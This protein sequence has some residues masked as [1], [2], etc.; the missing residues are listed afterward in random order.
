M[1]T[2]HEVHRRWDLLTYQN[3]I[4]NNLMLTSNFYGDDF[5]CKK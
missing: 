4:V 2:T 3:K 1:L 5:G